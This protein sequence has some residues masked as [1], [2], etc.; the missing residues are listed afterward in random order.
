MHNANTHINSATISSQTISNTFSSVSVP[1]LSDTDI[2]SDN[3][4]EDGK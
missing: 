2:I 1:D 3:E 4:N